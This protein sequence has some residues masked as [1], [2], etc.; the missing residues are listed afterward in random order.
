M[1]KIPFLLL[2]VLASCSKE[3]SIPPVPAAKGTTQPVVPSEPASRMPMMLGSR[4]C[5]KIT[6]FNSEDTTIAPVAKDSVL[7]YMDSTYSTKVGEEDQADVIL[8][9]DDLSMKNGSYLLT[10]Q[11]IPVPPSYYNIPLKTQNYTGS[12]YY[13]TF[14]PL[15]FPK[16]Y[17]ILMTDMDWDYDD[18]NC[19][20]RYKNIT[21]NKPSNYSFHAYPGQ[22]SSN[23][24]RFTVK[25]YKG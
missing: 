24:H 10:A 23:P 17:L 2:L 22:A 16:G 9:N 6:L 19:S 5:L 15:Y 1:K 20:V 25:I 3:L 12:H 18:Y 21:P 8:G 14:T 11:G 7:V 4:P 13:F